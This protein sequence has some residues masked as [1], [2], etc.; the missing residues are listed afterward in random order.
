[1]QRALEVRAVELIV[2]GGRRLVGSVPATEAR[3]RLAI[4]GR[5]D[6]G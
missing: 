6:A 4:M 5:F 2:A 3:T 1:M